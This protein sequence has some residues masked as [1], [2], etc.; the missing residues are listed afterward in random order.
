MELSKGSPSA[1]TRLYSLTAARLR[2]YCKIFLNDAVQVEDIVQN[3]YLRLWERREQ[4]RTDKSVESLLFTITRNQCLNDIRDRKL[5]SGTFS[6]DEFTWSDLQHLYQID[7]TGTE[8]K[9][10]EEQ[11]FEA[12]Q[13]AIDQLPVRQNQVFVLCKINGRKQKEVADELGISLKAVEKNL[14]KARHHLRE[15]L[16]ARFPDLSLFIFLLLR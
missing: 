14:A 1:Y 11:L 8:Q 2:N 4:I 9:I 15:R 6:I 7:F 16:T 13:E 10:L 12:L 3:T 5:A